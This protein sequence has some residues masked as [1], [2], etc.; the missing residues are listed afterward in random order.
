MKIREE[1]LPQILGKKL[2]TDERVIIE[3]KKDYD[4]IIRF[5]KTRKKVSNK[6]NDN[7]IEKSNIDAIVAEQIEEK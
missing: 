6:Q 2:S 7:I 1:I 5:L 3:G 4:E